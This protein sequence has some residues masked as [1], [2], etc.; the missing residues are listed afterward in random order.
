L[1][2]LTAAGAIAGCSPTH[3][4]SIGGRQRP[5]CAVPHTQL[6]AAGLHRTLHNRVAVYRVSVKSTVTFREQ[7]P[8]RVQAVDVAVM[9]RGTQSEAADSDNLAMG[10][11]GVL[12]AARSVGTAPTPVLRYHADRIG[13]YPVLVR[14]EYHEDSATCAATAQ[15]SDAPAVAENTAAVVR[16]VA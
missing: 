4:V 7:T 2:A 8:A 14:I 5:G 6:V 9:R 1:V 10:Q 3:A 15:P 12:A 16:V 11:P 13:T